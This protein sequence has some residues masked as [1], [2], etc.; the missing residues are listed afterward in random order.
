M[1]WQ[2]AGGVWIPI[3]VRF[4]PYDVAEFDEWQ[5][6]GPVVSRRR[7]YVGPLGRSSRTIHNQLRYNYA[8]VL[9]ASR[10]IENGWPPTHLVYENFR[11]STCALV[12][13]GLLG[14]GNAIV[15][16][17]FT[18]QYFHAVD[19]LIALNPSPFAK[20]KQAQH[21]TVDLFGW[22]CTH[23]RAGL[24]EVKRWQR[25]G[26]T[27]V[28]GHHQVAL[29]AMTRHLVATDPARYLHDPA[30]TFDTALIVFVPA[31]MCASEQQRAVTPAERGCELVI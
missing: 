12:A 22:D 24:W 23:R 2:Y 31:T 8:E 3:D 30:M 25:R 14:Q 26:G 21:C 5:T 11:L 27:E 10:L 18:G 17:V 13:D 9:W 19:R 1:R 6:G 29:L 20:K 7:D 15:R 16:S 4:E 28:V